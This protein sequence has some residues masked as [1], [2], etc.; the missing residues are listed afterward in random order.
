MPKPS[1]DPLYCYRFSRAEYDD[2]RAALVAS[3]A[4]SLWTP[5]GAALFVAF[6]AEWFRRDRSGGA[7]DWIRPLAA[8][9]I[10]YD[11]ND[12]RSDVTYAEVRTAV[13]DGL[14]FWGRPQP[15]D[16][17]WILAMVREAGFPAAATR[18]DPRLSTWLKRSVL[19][20]ERGFEPREAVGM[21][22]WRASERIVHALFDAVVE[23]CQA[24]AALRASLPPEQRGRGD[25][26]AV[27]DARDPSWRQRLPFELETRDIGALVEEAIR[28]RSDR[29]SA[30]A[31]TRRLVRKGNSW[32][33]RVCLAVAGEIEHVRVPAGLREGLDGVGRARVIGRGA[34]ADIARPFA[35]IE[36][37]LTPDRDVWEVRPLGPALEKDLPL[38]AD[39]RL[40]ALVGERVVAEFGALGGE[41]LDGVVI[42]EPTE[43]EEPEM[44]AGLLVRGSGPLRSRA[45]WLALAL[46][47]SVLDRVEFEDGPQMLGTI[48]DDDRI[49]VAFTGRAS[50]E[51]DGHRLS[52]VS[53]AE[54]EKRQRL[55]LVGDT[56]PRVREQVFLGAPKVWVEDEGV[57]TAPSATALRWRP[58][59]R[60]E[61]RPFDASVVG[62]V[63]IAWIVRGQICTT[64]SASVAPP[65]LCLYGRATPRQLKVEGYGHLPVAA[66]CDAP[67]SARRDG[68][69]TIFDLEPMQPGALVT[70]EL[71]VAGGLTLSLDDPSVEAVLVTPTGQAAGRRVHLTV[72]KLQGWRLLSSGRDRVRFEL[73]QR[74][75]V[76][77]H[78]TRSVDGAAPLAAYADEVRNLLGSADGLDLEVWMS[79]LGGSDRAAGIGWYDDR[80]LAENERHAARR[81]AFALLRPEVGAVDLE[82]SEPATQAA[83]LREKIGV[84]PWLICARS[85]AGEPLRPSVLVDR[86]AE[87]ADALGRA[88]NASLQFERAAAF[89]ALFVGEPAAETLRHLI[90]LLVAAR[91]EDLPLSALDAATAV[92]RS[93]RAAVY[94]LAACDSLEER[95]A[96][97]ALQRDLSFLWCATSLPIWLA[98]F[99]ARRV[100]IEARLAAFDID[101]SQAF[102]HVTAALCEIVDLAPALATHARLTFGLN[103][104]QRFPRD[105]PPLDVA[106]VARLMQGAVAPGQLRGLA[107]ELLTRRLD[108]DT[109][110]T[111]LGLS[112]SAIGHAPFLADCPNA[113]HDVLAAPYAAA[114]LAVG[115]DDPDPDLRA[116]CRRA[117]LFDPEYFESATQAAITLMA[118]GAA[119]SPSLE[120]AV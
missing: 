104:A 102:R 65:E 48:D 41:P 38:V 100:A 110:P 1:R 59:G 16:R 33:A 119:P 60:A 29:S 118:S 81:R 30:L 64:I 101:T 95:A 108:L 117:W 112:R 24:V 89:D 52:W 96:V 114:H 111:N 67:L 61:W 113:F 37:D 74:S 58:R 84:G 99:D 18:V 115:G 77:G 50:L 79:W 105:R 70:V 15:A 21:E 69:T 49:V 28:A 4:A 103:V 9:G 71:G 31:V 5:H 83:F 57:Y 120:A 22:S 63:E 12:P 87:P 26:V 73:E 44:A 35:A 36:R 51:V 25:P 109:P 47:R 66:R 14:A 72:G 7:W 10:R 27:L 56:V 94:A 82:M 53:A 90:Q 75:T 23:L 86:T 17:S 11:N 80:A 88:V 76:R 93:P 19:A 8:L 34:L 68:A 2:V 98:A 45:P 62:R 107:S 13:G 54:N 55:V 43:G 42:L 91:R 6:V 40:G 46:T 97:L 32:S 20:I 106:Q 3:G 85:A 39:V 92:C 78:F 116:A